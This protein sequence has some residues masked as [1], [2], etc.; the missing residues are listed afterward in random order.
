MLT[1]EISSDAVTR[2]ENLGL[3]RT[4]IT[5]VGLTTT[6]FRQVTSPLRTVVVDIPIR[7]A[8]GGEF[9]L[10]TT[11]AGRNA[12]RACRRRR[13]AETEA[14]HWSWQSS[15]VWLHSRLRECCS[16]S[17]TAKARLRTWTAIASM[18]SMQRWP[19]RWLPIQHSRRTPR[20]AEAPCKPLSEEKR[21]S[22]LPFRPTRLM[23]AASAE[24]SPRTAMRRRRPIAKATRTVRQVVEL[25]PVGFTYGVFSG[26][27]LR[28]RVGIICAR[29]DVHGR[30]CF[31]RQLQDY[32]GDVSSLGNIDTG[33][34]QKI[35]GTLHA[36]GNVNVIEQFHRRV[37][38]RPCWWQHQPGG[39]IRDAAAGGWHH[40][41]VGLPDRPRCRARASSTHLRLPSLVNSCRHSSG[42]PRTTYRSSPVNMA[43]TTF[44]ST[45]KNTNL[46]GVFNLTWQCRFQQ[47]GLPAADGRHH[48]LCTGELH[49]CPGRSPTTR[50]PA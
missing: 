34:N 42:M 27:E 16:R 31:A 24:F 5:G 15:S 45:K 7:S 35:T 10:Q 11:V 48:D 12:W 9:H 32:I 23:P 41:F 22:R 25:D 47:A 19:G 6:A 46:Q 30:Q 8:N 14:R 49:A 18:R 50:R 37:R 4:V 20:T 39:T 43:G 44:V 1:Y 13:R 33:S 40:R 26:G 17:P 2:T 38:K 3:P 29:R 36:N 28:R 21:S